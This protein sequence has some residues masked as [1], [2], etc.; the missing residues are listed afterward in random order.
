MP[1]RMLVLVSLAAAK[2]PLMPKCE[3]QADDLGAAVCQAMLSPKLGFYTC[4]KD[5]CPTCNDAECAPSCDAGPPMP[6]VSPS[7]HPY[8]APPSYN[9]Q[10]DQRGDQQ[11]T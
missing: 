1:R 10:D 9:Q 11:R 4:E 2:K 8:D 5:F 3:D 7:S 6:T